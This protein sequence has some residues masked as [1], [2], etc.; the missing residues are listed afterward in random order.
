MT[1]EEI[2]DLAMVPNAW[3]P[4]TLMEPEQLLFQ[5]FRYLHALYR[6]GGISRDQAAIEKQRF[7]VDHTKRVSQEAFRRKQSDHTVAM[8]RGI[9]QYTT[10][11]RKDRTLDNADKLVKAIQGDVHD[12]NMRKLEV[13]E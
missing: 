4:E 7:V 13:M 1:V 10:A 8:W 11:Y 12:W 9:S 5:K 3:M 2:E 6:I